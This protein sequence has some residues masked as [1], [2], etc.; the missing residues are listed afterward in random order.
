MT[1]AQK[2]EKIDAG[3]AGTNHELDT[4]KRQSTRQAKKPETKYESI[5]RFIAEAKIEMLKSPCK[6]V[7]EKIDRLIVLQEKYSR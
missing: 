7:A 2:A 6:S 5:T 4:S 1:Y 3:L